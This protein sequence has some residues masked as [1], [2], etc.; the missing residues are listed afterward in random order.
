MPTQSPASTSSETS[1][2]A[3]TQPLSTRNW[4]VRLRMARSGA[5]KSIAS[6]QAR[7][8][9]VAKRI[10]EQVQA[11]CGEADGDAGKQHHPP[12][13]CGIVAALGDDVAPTGDRR[14]DTDAKKAKR[15]FRQHRI[16][17]DECEMHQQRAE[18]IRQDMP[19]HDPQRGSA[20]N[21]RK[22]MMTNMIA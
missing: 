6:L 22:P 9:H 14:L 20:R 15:R 10:A 18:A 2:I 7:V 19:H 11:Q 12:G 3:V 4:T 1:S 8:E 16:G 5:I 21:L 17:K 13:L